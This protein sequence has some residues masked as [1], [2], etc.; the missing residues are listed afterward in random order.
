MSSFYMPKVTSLDHQIILGYITYNDDSWVPNNV[1]VTITNLD[2]DDSAVVYTVISDSGQTGLY[3]FDV[4]DVEANDGDTIF[5]DVS[6]GGCVGNNSIVVDTSSPPQ[7][8]DVT[9]CCNLPPNKT[10]QPSGDTLANRSI[11]YT[12]STSTTDPDGDDIYYWFDWG[13]QTNSGW[14]GPYPSG[15][16][17]NASNSWDA[18]GDYKVKCKAKDTYGAERGDGWSDPLTVT[19]TNRA[20]SISSKPSGETSGYISYLYSY[21]TI[22]TDPDGDDI[23]YWFDWGDQTNSGWEGPYDSGATGVKI[24]HEWTQPGNYSIKAKAKDEYDLETEAGW[25]E[26]LNVTITDPPNKPPIA[27]FT[28]SPKNPLKNTVINFTDTSF[29]LD[30]NITSW[31]WDFDD[32]TNST[33]RNTSHTYPQT[34]NYKVS[35]T[36]TDNES[37]TDTVERTITVSS[38]SKPPDTDWKDTSEITLTH[39]E[40]NKGINYL[41]WKGE[42]INASDLAEK[43]SLS[44]GESIAIFDETNGGWQKYTIGSSTDEDDFL[45]S[46]M[47][48]ISIKCKTEKKINVD[49]SK[50]SETTQSITISFVSDTVTKKSNEGYN[51]FAWTSDQTLS[52]KEFVELYNFS[53]ENIEISVYNT[54]DNTWYTYNPSV[55]AV[56]HNSFNIQTYDIICIKVSKKSTEHMLTI[57]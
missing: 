15:A 30:G 28:Y 23:Y 8:C 16:T 7:R 32:G 24:Y 13:D 26:P 49:I 57:T 45:V 9:I 52:T 36:V 53:N 48:V 43:I 56:F 27:D 55:P 40:K 34:G 11:L 17:V 20:P 51:F 35:L 29:D 18:P 37:R 41:T 46:P 3:V 54:A 1:T 44:N 21:S 31:Y 5:V 4:Y 33:T 14:I 25:S 10:S 12:Y 19:I 47:D 22:A 6:Y 38:T 42:A 50:Q 39:N 2:Q